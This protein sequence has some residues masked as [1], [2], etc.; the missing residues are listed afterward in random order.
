MG[1]P[2]S[3]LSPHSPCLLCLPLALLLRLTPCCVYVYQLILLRIERI[4]LR[5]LHSH[6]DSFG[7]LYTSKNDLQ[8]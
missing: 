3:L 1:S 8:S 7:R 6:P 4:D 5:T 2:S